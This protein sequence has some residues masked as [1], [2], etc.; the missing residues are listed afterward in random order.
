LAARARLGSLQKGRGAGGGAPAMPLFMHP[1]SEPIDAL[2]RITASELLLCSPL[3]NGRAVDV[4]RRR[5]DR[6]GPH[7]DLRALAPFVRAASPALEQLVV[8]VADAF[9]QC[10]SMAEQTAEHSPD[11]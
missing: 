11:H 5:R 4:C 6:A 7:A 3:L 1:G 9:H 10:P 8:P 2:A